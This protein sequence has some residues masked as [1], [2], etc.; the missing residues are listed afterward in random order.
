[1]AGNSAS[2]PTEGSIGNGTKVEDT[3]GGN[4]DGRERGGKAPS[5][6]SALVDSTKIL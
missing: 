3:E 5:A 2:F 1:V 6:Q 4:T